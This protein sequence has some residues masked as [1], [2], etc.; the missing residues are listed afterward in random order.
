MSATQQQPPKNHQ[1]YRD[2]RKSSL[3]PKTA[4]TPSGLGDTVTHLV[5]TIQEFTERFN[6]IARLFVWAVTA[7]S[8]FD[9]LER[10]STRI[11]GTEH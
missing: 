8:I 7:Q 1:P 11:S 10:L 6:Q 5:K 9:I 2:S 4:R 3:I